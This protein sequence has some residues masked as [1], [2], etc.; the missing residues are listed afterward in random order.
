MAQ[1]HVDSEALSGTTTSLRTTV[2]QMQSLVQTL[3]SQ[4]QTLAGSWTGSAALA[5][6]DLVSE[7]QG[8]QRMVESNLDEISVALSTANDHY[9]EVEAAN[10]SLF[11]R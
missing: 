1:F 11:A 3:Q 5:F 9:A 8:T 2:S 10:M 7:W 6:Q 4:L